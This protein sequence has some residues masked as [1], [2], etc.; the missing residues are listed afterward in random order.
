MVNEGQKSTKEAYSDP[1]IVA[2]YIE[3]NAKNPKLFD[4]V[5]RFAK[6]ISGKKKS[7]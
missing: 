2:G 4:V 3:A 1:Q 7:N 5:E 6:T